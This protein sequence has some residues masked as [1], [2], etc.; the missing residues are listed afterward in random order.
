MLVFI[1]A[2]DYCVSLP[3]Q[4]VLQRLHQSHLVLSGGR[5]LEHNLWTSQT[6]CPH[7]QL[8]VLCHVEHGLEIKV[9]FHSLKCDK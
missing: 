4:N 8:V 6:L 9:I 1:S 3:C 5:G 7:K 2:C